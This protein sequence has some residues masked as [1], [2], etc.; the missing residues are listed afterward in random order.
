MNIDFNRIEKDLLAEHY[1]KVIHKI[2]SYHES[3]RGF[4]LVDLLEKDDYYFRYMT[5]GILLTLMSMNYIK[6]FS[7][8]NGY[9]NYVYICR[10]KIEVKN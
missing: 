1:D 10:T 2:N 8:Y 6:I 7:T 5:K 3:G 4:I 9:K